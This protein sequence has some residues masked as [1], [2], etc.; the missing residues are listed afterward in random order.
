MTPHRK[1]LHYSDWGCMAKGSRRC[2]HGQNQKPQAWIGSPS[3]HPHKCQGRCS[4]TTDIKWIAQTTAQ[5]GR[6]FRY[7]AAFKGF[8]AG[9]GTAALQSSAWVECYQG[10]G[11]PHAD[12]ACSQKLLW[13]R[14][15]E[16]LLSEKT[17]ISRKYS[18]KCFKTPKHSLDSLQGFSFAQQGI[19]DQ[20]ETSVDSFDTH[21]L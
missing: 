18:K 13:Y 2:V 19:C 8:A 10:A 21:S 16:V 11:Q 4:P 15:A 14:R 12:T 20:Q 7:H 9:G 3:G 6:C 1:R 17:S 5:S